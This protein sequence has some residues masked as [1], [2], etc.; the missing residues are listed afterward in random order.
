M[1]ASSASAYV[2]PVSTKRTSTSA[3]NQRRI[4][5]EQGA[6]RIQDHPSADD[7]GVYGNGVEC[8]RLVYGSRRISNDA[9]NRFCFNYS[10]GGNWCL[11]HLD[12]T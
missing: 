4:G 12:V 8:V 10:R 1:F 5:D 3:T 11:W 7:A 9:A 6:A 2:D